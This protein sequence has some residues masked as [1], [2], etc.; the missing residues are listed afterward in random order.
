MSSATRARAWRS[1]SRRTCRRCWRR[2]ASCPALEHVVVVDGD[3][4]EGT[5]ALDD[6]E[7]AAEASDFDLEPRSRAVS[8]TTSLTLIYTSGT[9]GPPKGVELTHR[10]IFGAVA[11]SHDDD[12]A[13]AAARR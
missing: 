1:S 2:A 13:A 5:V 11:R 4:P 3:A 9:T 7:A 6:V 8:P 10:N 12:R